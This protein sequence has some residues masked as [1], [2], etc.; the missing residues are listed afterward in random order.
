[1]IGPIPIAFGTSP[2]ITIIAMVIGLILMLLMFFLGR[3]NNKEQNIPAKDTDEGLEG[4]I[5]GGGVILVGPIPVVFGT[6]KRYAIIAI[7]LAILLLLLAMI[8][9]NFIKCC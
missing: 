5:K 6:D 3:K 4:K 2:E 8:S 7:V 9:F 1:M